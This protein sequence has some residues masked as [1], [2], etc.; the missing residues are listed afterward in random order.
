MLEGTRSQA[1]AEESCYGRVKSQLR[2]EYHDSKDKGQNL[3][4][5]VSGVAGTQGVFKSGNKGR[6]HKQDILESIA[7]YNFCL[8]TLYLAKFISF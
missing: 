2:E 8:L 3:Q 5:R 7:K 6:D 1:T 4:H